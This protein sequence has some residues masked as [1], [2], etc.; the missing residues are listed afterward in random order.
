MWNKTK[1]VYKGQIDENTKSTL[2]DFLAND[3]EFYD[4]VKQRFYTV[5]EKIRSLKRN[6]DRKRRKQQIVEKDWNYVYDYH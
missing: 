5:L 6:E 4:F 2:K 3:Y 1:T